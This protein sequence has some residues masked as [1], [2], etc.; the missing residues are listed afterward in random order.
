MK[1]KK[2]EKKA[3]WR[4]QNLGGRRTIF[5]QAL[6]CTNHPPNKIYPCLC[7]HPSINLVIYY[8]AYA[9]YYCFHEDK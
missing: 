6:K 8:F 7:I 5:E 9:S 1:K 3:T 2:K 4:K